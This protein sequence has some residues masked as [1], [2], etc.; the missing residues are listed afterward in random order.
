MKKKNE[1]VTEIS[2]RL[3]LSKVE[4]E[5]VI[6]T[7]ADVVKD[8]L[9]DGHSIKIRGFIT[10]D[11]YELKEREGYN[12]ITGEMEYFEPV[13]TVRCK[14]GKPIKEAINKR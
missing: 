3:G 13:K 5:R 10:F 2:K 6:E 4:C 8:Y 14:I 12:P 11:I 7:F 9:V 1:V